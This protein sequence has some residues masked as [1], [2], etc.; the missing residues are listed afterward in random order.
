MTA[1]SDWAIAAGIL[2][3]SGLKT[4]AVLGLAWGTTRVLS[5]GSAAQRHAVWACALASLP[6]LPWLAWHRGSAI[7]L[8]ASWIA[9]VWGLGVLV[10]TLPL[11]RGVLGLRRLLARAVEDPVIPRLFTSDELAAPITWGLF[12]PV[13][14]LPS[15]AASWPA[16]HRAAALAHERA[17][18]ARF[19]WAVHLATWLVAAAFW[20]HPLVWL[21][22]RELAREA[23]HAADDRVLAEGVRP[24]DYAS[25]L[26]SLAGAGT[27]RTALGAAPSLVG[28]RVRAVLDT[29]S[30]SA[31][32]WPALAVAAALA[33]A[34]LPAL[35][36]WP[37][38]SE[39]VEAELTCT[40][41][42][43]TWPPSP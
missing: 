4:T 23:E 24:S 16:P 43:F 7:A 30:R 39:P 1:P 34:S 35:A 40:P 20:F 2:V 36:A 38:W 6:A 15:A 31:R 18:I 5:W 37:A 25:L 42:P 29:R 33:L 13:V 26:V 11:L 28:S 14:V 41:E 17:H 27:P 22:R 8:D 10:A 32:R 19:D 21:A 12:R 3:D 9:P